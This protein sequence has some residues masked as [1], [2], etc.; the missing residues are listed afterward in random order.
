MTCYAPAQHWA[1]AEVSRDSV[2]MVVI[3]P[4]VRWETAARR[5]SDSDALRTEA[6]RKLPMSSGLLSLAAA[7]R[8]PSRGR[9]AFGGIGSAVRR[10]V[11]AQIA[12]DRQTFARLA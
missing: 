6:W 7:C 5:P 8:A 10:H 1:G 4:Q 2:I 12:A 3:D 9:N 11:V